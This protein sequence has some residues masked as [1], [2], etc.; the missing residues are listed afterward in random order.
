[1][2]RG[3]IRSRE[4]IFYVMSKLLWK[5]Y[6]YYVPSTPTFLLYSKCT[7]GGIDVL[8]MYNVVRL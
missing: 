5:W 4:H 6:K 1:L 3:I 7:A 8:Y 2:E